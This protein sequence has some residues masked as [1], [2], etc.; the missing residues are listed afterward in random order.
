MSYA[1]YQKQRMTNL[2]PLFA[3]AF[4]QQKATLREMNLPAPKLVVLDDGAYFLE[5]LSHHNW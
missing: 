5:A 1:S 4:A 3:S 2:L